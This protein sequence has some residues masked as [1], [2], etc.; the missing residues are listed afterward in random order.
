MAPCP[1]AR[2]SSSSRSRS[3]TKNP[4]LFEITAGIGLRVAG[5]RQLA[6]KEPFFG[7]IAQA[8]DAQS[9][10][11]RPETSKELRHRP[12]AAD[13]H[14]GHAFF[15]QVSCLEACQ[16]LDR[17]LIADPLD[18]HNG[19][20]VL[21][22]FQGICGCSK[23]S[24]R[25]ARVSG[26]GKLPAAA[27]R[28]G[29]AVAPSICAAVGSARQ[30][31]LVEHAGFDRRG[32]HRRVRRRTPRIGIVRTLI[33]SHGFALIRCLSRCTPRLATALRGFHFETRSSFV[34]MP[35]PRTEGLRVHPLQFGG[36]VVESNS[37]ACHRLAIQTGDEESDARW[38]RRSTG[39]AC[40][41]SSE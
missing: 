14:H 26:D 36:S 25:P 40:L 17:N 4:A 29:A 28:A 24:I 23:R 9:G 33:E 16:S 10:A 41:C 8:A 3:H 11:G 13:R 1:T 30:S 39:K 12:S 34:A 32:R 38:N 6:A 2:M 19:T 5:P 27:S 18:Q 22:A 7:S 35:R 20:S 21:G 37:A 15:R 31:L